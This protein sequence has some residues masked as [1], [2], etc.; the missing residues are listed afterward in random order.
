MTSDDC[1]NFDIPVPTNKKSSLIEPA[2]SDALDNAV[3]ALFG[4]KEHYLPPGVTTPIQGFD[5][6][7]WKGTGEDYS[8]LLASYATTGFQATYV[9]QAVNSI[10]D[11]VFLFYRQLIHVLMYL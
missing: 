8:R 4:H 7:G 9:A 11:M 10:N 5:F 6:N 3:D 1:K 2:R